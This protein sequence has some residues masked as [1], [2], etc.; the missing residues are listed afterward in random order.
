MVDFEVEPMIAERRSWR[1]P[2]L[3]GWVVAS[4][5]G[6]GACA[7]SPAPVQSLT[8]TRAA[9]R[10]AAEMGA[11]EVPRASLHLKLAEEGLAAA[12]AEIAD[13]DGDEARPYLAR[14]K[15]DAELAL[16]YAKS[17]RTRKEALEARR[18]VD[19]LQRR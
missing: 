11:R 14:A 7:S 17:E 8:E 15:A 16:A 5:L 6:L 1:W 19:E 3:A 10:S 4:A 13:G 2:A 12:E 9:V 18:K